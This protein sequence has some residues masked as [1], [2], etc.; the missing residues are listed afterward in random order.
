MDEVDRRTRRASFGQKFQIRIG[1]VVR[2]QGQPFDGE[3]AAP[4]QCLIAAMDEAISEFLVEPRLLCEQAEIVFFG[5]LMVFFERLAFASRTAPPVGCRFVPNL[6][7]ASP[8]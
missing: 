8:G 6:V 5:G 1:N 7:R 3:V 4:A 2:K